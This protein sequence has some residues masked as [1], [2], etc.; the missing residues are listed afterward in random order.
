MSKRLK[1]YKV[2][3]DVEDWYTF[4]PDWVFIKKVRALSPLK[5]YDA[6]RGFSPGIFYSRL[7]ARLVKK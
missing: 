6:I 5:A 2:Y 7:Q 1:T 4:P 3:E